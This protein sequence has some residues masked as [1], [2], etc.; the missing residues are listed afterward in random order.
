MAV[1]LGI[2]A[3][4]C[5]ADIYIRRRWSFLRMVDRKTYQIYLLAWFPQQFVVAILYKALHW[6]YWLCTLLMFAGGLLLP[7]LVTH[8]VQFHAPWARPL[9]GMSGRKRLALASVRQGV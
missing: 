5:F 9:L 2:Y 3:V 6:N 7:L 4:Y 1:L 8:L